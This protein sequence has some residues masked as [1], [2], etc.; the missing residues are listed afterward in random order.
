M[1]QSAQT[2]ARRLTELLVQQRDLYLQ[3]RELARTQAAAVLDERPED[4][5]RVLGDRQRRITELLE[6]N[7]LL[8][9]FRSR[10]GELREAMGRGERLEVGELV[11]QVQQLLA[12]ILQQDEGDCDA[13]R[14]RTESHRNA[15]AVVS[16]GQRLNAAYAAAGR[17]A[18][19]P[20]YVDCSDQEGDR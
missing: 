1:I 8:E 13:L 14:Q 4:L 15:A 20:R 5:L 19:T 6:I 18:G 11:E 3:L 7:A 2:E 17:V 10:W 12:E 9:P 16:V